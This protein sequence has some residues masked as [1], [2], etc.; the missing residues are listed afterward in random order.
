MI[1]EKII[2][3]YIIRSS[4]KIKIN[5]NEVKKGDIFIALQG[6]NKHGNEYIESSIKNGAKFCLTDKKIKKNL[7]N[8]NILFIK[9]IFSFLKA[10]SLKKRSL[11]K[12]KVLGITGSAGKTSLKESLSF[13]LE[14]KYK[15]S[16][17]FKSYNNDLGVLI[18]LLNLNIK[19]EFAIFE[20]GTNNHGEIKSLVQLVKPSQVFITNIQNTHLE[21]FKTKKNIAIEKS[22][23]F[24]PIY[25]NNIKSIILLNTNKEEKL[26]VNLAKKFK[27]K[28]IL[29]IG[30]S[31]KQNCYIKKISKINDYYKVEA[32]INKKKFEFFMRTDIS[33]RITNILFCLSFFYLNKLD[34][35]NITNNTTKIKPFEGRGSVINKKLFNLKIKFID[36]T[37]N[38]NPDTMKQS[39]YYFNNMHLKGYEKI[40]ILGNMNELGEFKD[41]FHLKT[42]EYVEK[43]KFSFVILCG[44]L[45]FKALKKI[46]KPSNKYVLLNNEK[47]IIRYLKN[48]L[49][50]NST[51]MAKCSNS[52]SVNKF[53]KLLLSMKGDK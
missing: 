33:Y 46:K 35:K 28:N 51:I 25:N 45:F 23:I 15:T 17:T 10:L 24:N 3:N 39:I 41:K 37:Y 38:A 31:N 48:N 9:N 43:F 5:S 26:L 14:K 32:I 34:K 22:A 4:N 29:T 27:I 53:A 13:F 21:N 8:E 20:L 7:V 47:T 50:K 40:L 1:T 11:F 12:G 44:N 19:S 6:N 2:Q 30:N 52:T 36:E 18:S 42:L 16:K 49:H